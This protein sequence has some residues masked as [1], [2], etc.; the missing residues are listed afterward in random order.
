MA[1][2]SY[3]GGR[4]VFDVAMSEFAEAYADQNER[5]H[6]RFV[7]AARDQ[8]VDVALDTDPWDSRG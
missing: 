4:E 8:H 2:A 6:A 1:I 3:L 5:D 7:A